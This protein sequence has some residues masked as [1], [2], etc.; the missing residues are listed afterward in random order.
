MV[1]FQEDYFDLIFYDMN[2]GVVGT[3]SELKFLLDL[4]DLL[5]DRKVIVHFFNYTDFS[6][7]YYLEDRVTFIC[8][9]E[10]WRKHIEKSKSLREMF[11][12]FIEIVESDCLYTLRYTS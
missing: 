3:Q 2:K 9:K 12:K 8:C 11:D 5:S 1:E 4:R 6:I 7:R 10:H